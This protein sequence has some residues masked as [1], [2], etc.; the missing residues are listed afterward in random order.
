VRTAKQGETFVTLDQKE[1]VLDPETLMICDGEKA[2]AVGGVMG[3][4]NSEIEDN[5]TRVLLESAYFDPVSIRRTSKRLG[6][7]TDASHRF[8]RG[9]DPEGQIAAANRAA[10]LMA[11]LGGGRLISGLIDE[12]PNQQSVKSVQLSVKNTNRLLG[13]QL[14]RKEI[15]NFLKSIE[16]KVEKTKGNTSKFPC[17]YLQTG[18][19]YGRS[20]P[21]I[22]I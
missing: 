22:G 4:L 11:E 16:F 20:R 2:V 13:T 18:R 14:Q 3:G 10:M 8:E 12:Y 9:I 19:P 17:G 7:N 15:E 6:L 5:T 1:R 21:L